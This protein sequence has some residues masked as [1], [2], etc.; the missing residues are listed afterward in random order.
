MDQK[1][2]E[3][4]ADIAYVAGYK[5]FTTGNSRADINSFIYWA[6]EFE[7]I[8]QNTCW[9]EKDYMEEV[10]KFAKKRLKK[11]LKMTRS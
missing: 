6:K 3:A 7:N 9:E 8:H 4:I 5:K 1:L 11:E 2:A 10:E